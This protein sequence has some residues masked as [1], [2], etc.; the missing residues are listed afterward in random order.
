MNQAERKLDELLEWL[1]EFYDYEFYKGRPN[2]IMIKDIYGEYQP[3][4]RKIPSQEKRT[5]EKM[6]K[7]TNF[8]IAALGTEYKPNS[9][10]KVARD[11]IEAF[12]EKDFGHTY[13]E[14]I[15]R[16]YVKEPFDKYG[17]TNDIKVWVYY[18]TYEPLDIN[19]LEDWRNILR[20]EHIAE[21]EA[22]NAFYRHAEG[23]DITKEIGYYKSARNRF[24]DKYQ[25]IPILVKN[26]KLKG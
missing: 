22:A 9:K 12:G 2:R 4:P 11:A 26:W 19:V 24:K 7:Y 8:T 25:D 17:E 5:K 18:S 10:T 1:K 3:L 14:G 15:V 6:E 16:N 21:D 23:E 20:E 13:V